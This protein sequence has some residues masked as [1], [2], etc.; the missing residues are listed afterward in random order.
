MAVIYESTAASPFIVDELISFQ[1][2]GAGGGAGNLS[3]VEA[4]FDRTNRTLTVVSFLQD[5]Q[6]QVIVS[7]DMD[8]TI[9]DELGQNLFAKALTSTDGIFRAIFPNVS[10]IPNR[11]LLADMEF[12]VGPNTIPT[13]RPLTV[14][15]TAG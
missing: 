7:T 1:T 9:K 13:T 4:V 14:L 12:T 8:L 15:G 10:I 5:T 2:A 3:V 6:G 11:I